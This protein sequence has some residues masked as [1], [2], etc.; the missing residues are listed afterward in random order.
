MST[1]LKE[2]GFKYVLL[3]VVL[4]LFYVYHDNLKGFLRPTPPPQ[5]SVNM[6]V[7]PPQAVKNETTIIKEVAVQPQSQPGAVVTFVERAGKVIAVID[8]KEIEVPNMTGKPTAEL[9][10]DGELRITQNMTARIDVTDMVRAQVNEHLNKQAQELK[11]KYD[12]HTALSVEFT[13]LDASLDYDNKGLRLTGGVTWKG[14]PR[15]GIGY[16]KEF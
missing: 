3:A 12:K 13:N 15:V 1:Y 2:N 16:R 4:L 14:E 11:K 6:P 5:I 9:G 10:K 7:V 8:G